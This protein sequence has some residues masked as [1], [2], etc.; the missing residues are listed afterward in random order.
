MV[1]YIDQ[2]DKQKLSFGVKEKSAI[3]IGIVVLISIYF[4]FFHVDRTP[5]GYAEIPEKLL[6]LKDKPTVKTKTDHGID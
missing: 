3:G 6:S 2:Y 4:M 5:Y 1:R